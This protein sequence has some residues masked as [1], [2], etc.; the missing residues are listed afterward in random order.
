ME[1]RRLHPHAAPRDIRPQLRLAGGR[2]GRN[3]HRRFRDTGHARIRAEPASHR[4]PGGAG[5]QGTH[6]RGRHQAVSVPGRHARR[7][8]D[9]LHR[10]ADA[11][12]R[13]LDP[14]LQLDHAASRRF[15]RPP[16]RDDPLH[17]GAAR[18]RQ[19][20]RH[21]APHR[22]D[23]ARYL[24]RQ[25]RRRTHSRRADPPRPQRHDAGRDLA[26][27]PARLHRAVRPA[28]SRDRGRYPEPLFR[29]RSP[30]SAAMAAR[31]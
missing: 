8:R 19:R 24:C 26:L 23:A 9:R 31:C 18:A 20:D 15:Q 22:R 28:A 17:R 12:S 30:R 7:R 5:G 29:L 14:R 3:R 11:V 1:V 27:G 2:G 13:R 25:S 6:R 21:P 16:H 4:I 10:D